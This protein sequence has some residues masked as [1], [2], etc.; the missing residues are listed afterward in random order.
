[1]P[2]PA[3]QSDTYKIQTHP[4]DTGSSPVKSEAEQRYQK[5]YNEAISTIS[6]LREQCQYTNAYWLLRVV[7]Q[8]KSALNKSFNSN[9]LNAANLNSARENI[10][11]V[12]DSMAFVPFLDQLLSLP[13]N[14]REEQP[15]KTALLAQ[16]RQ[17]LLEATAKLDD[18][19]D[20]FI[21]ICKQPSPWRQAMLDFMDESKAKMLKLAE[22]Q[23][24]ER[25]VRGQLKHYTE[26]VAAIVRSTEAHI[27]DECCLDR[28]VLFRPL[29]DTLDKL[30]AEKL[31][32]L[33]SNGDFLHLHALEGVRTTFADKIKSAEANLTSKANITAYAAWLESG[34]SALKNTLEEV[35]AETSAD[36]ITQLDRLK[37]L[38]S[39]HYQTLH[40]RL[41][42][43]SQVKLNAYVLLLERYQKL[44]VEAI[45][46]LTLKYPHVVSACQV[47]K[48]KVATKQ[49][50]VDALRTNFTV[51]LNFWDLFP[52]KV[53]LKDLPPAQLSE[54]LKFIDT[55]IQT[56]LQELTEDAAK[57]GFKWQ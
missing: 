10:E 57:I 20:A 38:N 4:L 33:T 19:K 5:V 24:T 41:I 13:E 36:P 52:G 53:P 37:A 7:A 56:N 55:T 47:I 49:S 44:L 6:E 39:P 8:Q 16:Q 14:S 43:N 40:Q 27:Q 25:L 3:V 31:P 51:R 1:M 11:N 42:N 18:Q 2:I 17:V 50:Q 54:Y 46:L 22:P 12:L 28:L 34:I 9:T 48:E 35:N 32:M 26:S 30:A 23:E 45:P 15:L 29:Y 21:D